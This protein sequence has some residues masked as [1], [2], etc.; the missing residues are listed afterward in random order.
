MQPTDKKRIKCPFCSL[1]KS[2]IIMI[3]DG[4]RSCNIHIV[5]ILKPF[6]RTRKYTITIRYIVS[7]ATR[8]LLLFRS[9]LGLQLKL[10]AVPG[11]NR[12]I[13]VGPPRAIIPFGRV[14]YIYTDKCRTPLR[15]AMTFGEKA[16]NVI[17]NVFEVNT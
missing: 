4:W 5:I 12:I 1:H 17:Y 3:D 16:E 10:L 13:L 2:Y 8:W 7:R 6:R 11:S 14:E 9:A 15:S